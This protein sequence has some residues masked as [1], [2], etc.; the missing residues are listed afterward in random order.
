MPLSH[1]HLLHASCIPGL[2]GSLQG[3]WTGDM[4]HEAVTRAPS[5]PPVGRREGRSP[6]LTT[7]SKIYAFLHTAY[8][9]SFSGANSLS[10]SKLAT[11][12]IIFLPGL[13]ALASSSP[14]DSTLYH[15]HREV[16]RLMTGS[17][18]GLEHG[19]SDDPPVL[20]LSA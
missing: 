5:A 4:K 20:N 14:V 6:S 10:S 2:E 1:K 12:S 11:V 19:D 13:L 7:Q 8:K 15:G 9:F 3:Q 16:T 18:A 17:S